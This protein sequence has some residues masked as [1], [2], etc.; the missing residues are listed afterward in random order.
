MQ[1]YTYIYIYTYMLMAVVLL[2]MEYP[3]SSN[4]TMSYF[5]FWSKTKLL[6]YYNC[7]R[8]TFDTFADFTTS[9]FFIEFYR[10]KIILTKR[11]KDLVSKKKCK[12]NH[13]SGVEHVD[14]HLVLL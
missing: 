1:C 7:N 6:Q 2:R 3:P 12:F 10:L 5:T 13:H 11:R 8:S 14:S 4:T 9:C